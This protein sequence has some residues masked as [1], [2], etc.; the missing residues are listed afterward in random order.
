MPTP[1]LG[2]QQVPGEAIWRLYRMKVNLLAAGALPRT[3][4]G[5]LQSSIASI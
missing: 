5:S 1:E 4:L 2:L 3:P